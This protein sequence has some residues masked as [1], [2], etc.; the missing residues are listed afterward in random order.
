[1][2][3]GAT[4]KE[5]TLLNW[6]HPKMSSLSFSLLTSATMQSRVG[7]GSGFRVGLGVEGG[8]PCFLLA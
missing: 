8:L 4:L 5:R 1:M 6:G 7:L 2:L 3:V